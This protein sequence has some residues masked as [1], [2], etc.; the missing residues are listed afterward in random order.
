MRTD[1]GKILLV[2]VRTNYLATTIETIF[3]DVVT[4]VH[5]AGGFIHGQR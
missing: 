2:V 3:A 5:F 1:P 4:Q